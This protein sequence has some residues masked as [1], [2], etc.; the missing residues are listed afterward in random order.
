[1]TSTPKTTDLYVPYD[2]NKPPELRDLVYHGTDDLDVEDFHVEW[3]NLGAFAQ[4]KS[5]LVRQF[6]LNIWRQI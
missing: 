6:L 2:P 4:L 3:T 5:R 1:M